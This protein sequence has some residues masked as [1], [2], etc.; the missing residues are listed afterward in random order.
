MVHQEEGNQSQA[1]LKCSGLWDSLLVGLKQ[2]M[3]PLLPQIPKQ[4]PWNLAHIDYWEQLWYQNQG[5][6]QK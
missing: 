4:L 1:P 3:E 5:F 2:K 6:H